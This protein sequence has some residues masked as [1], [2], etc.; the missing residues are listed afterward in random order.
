MFNAKLIPIDNVAEDA[1]TRLNLCDTRLEG[2]DP[3]SPR[4]STTD[5]VDGDSFVPALLRGVGN[6]CQRIVNHPFF[7]PRILD[8]ERNRFPS[9]ES[10]KLHPFPTL[11]FARQGESWFSRIYARPVHTRVNLNDD[12]DT[13][14]LFTGCTVDSFDMLFTVN[15]NHNIRMS[16]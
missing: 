8:T 2:T 3:V 16:P 9:K 5:D 11:D 6:G 7:L 4:P 10:R 13:D 1:T 15:S 14:S 12:A